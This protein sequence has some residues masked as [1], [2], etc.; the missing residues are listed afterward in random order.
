MPSWWELMITLIA[1]V[2]LALLISEKGSRLWA[3]GIAV[4]VWLLAQFSIIALAFVNAWY[5]LVS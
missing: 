5:G 4:S 2:G 3:A 1:L